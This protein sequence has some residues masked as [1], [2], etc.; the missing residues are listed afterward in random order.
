MYHISPVEF[1]ARWRQTNTSAT[2]SRPHSLPIGDGGMMPPPNNPSD[3][4]T[5]SVRHAMVG[6]GPL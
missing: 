6:R 3:N 2:L 5:E 1:E 4:V